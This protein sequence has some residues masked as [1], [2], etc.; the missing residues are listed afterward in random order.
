MCRTKD[1][2]IV[3]SPQKSGAHLICELMSRLD[4]R[5]LGWIVRSEPAGLT[6]SDM[7]AM[8]RSVM[9]QHEKIIFGVGRP[10]GRFKSKAR[11]AAYLM[12]ILWGERLGVPWLSRHGLGDIHA[13][14]SR[15]N[16]AQLTARGFDSFPPNVCLVKH[17]LPLEKTDG[18]F[19]RDWSASGDPALILMYRD[20]RDVLC[21]FVRYL[22]GRTK[23][24]QHGG[25][26][27]YHAYQPILQSLP[28]D[29]ERLMHA[30][31]DPSFPGHRDYFESLWLLRHPNVCKVKYEEL[32]GD[33]GGGSD[34][35]QTAAV[36]RVLEH[37][38]IDAD[39]I[40]CAQGIY[41]TE[42]FTFSRGQIGAWR[43]MFKLHHHEVFNDRYGQVL[44][45][46]GYE[47]SPPC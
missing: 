14:Y 9:R 32:V 41:N 35:A 37:L 34:E 11:R 22:T 30:I 16:L 12:F 19:I 46:Y 21:S 20:P 42:S 36:S 15:A 31:V 25:F 13:I 10:L 5:V 4:Y 29:D 44:E 6:D 45:W 39:P 43:E 28:N 2:V 23:R 7:D 1:R 40:E 3:V 17:E 38:G 33:A 27:E 47:P 8:A 26:A 24:K 18:Q